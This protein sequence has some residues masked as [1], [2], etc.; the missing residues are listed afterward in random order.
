M[1]DMSSGSRR[2]RT[3]KFT[4]LC[5]TAAVSAFALG[6]G[7]QGAFAQNV[8]P[9]A[10]TTG[11]E[12]VVVVTGQRK[13]AQSAQQ[14]KRR[15]DVVVDTMVAEDAGKLPDNNV[16]DALARV[17]GV[18][19]RRDSGEANS[20]L[21]RGL[22]NIVTLLNG[23]EMFTTTGRYVAL[24]DVP[25]NMI[26]RVD[27]YKSNGASQIE[28]GIA[29]TIDVRTRRPF[30]QKGLQFNA[31]VRAQ[32]NDKAGA[33]DP[34]LG[35]TVS[36]TWDTSHGQFGALLGLS[37]T[38]SHFHEER[39]FN[40]ESVD[41]TGSFP[42][43]TLP[44]GLTSIKAPFV[45]GYIPITGDRRRTSANVAL[46]WRPNEDT[47]VYFEGFAT[48]YKND[49]ELD[50][51][52]GLP[53]LGDGNISATVYPGTNILKTLTNHNVFTI[54]STQ[55]NRQK[56]FTTQFAV[57]GTHRMGN[58]KA[59]T[60]LAVTDSTFDYENP[61]L[62]TA[63]IVPLVKVDTNHNGTAQ[64]DYGGPG[65]DIK[66]SNGF[67]LANW[68]DNYGHD[69]GKSVDWSGDLTYLPD[70]D[71]TLKEFKAGV[72]F[73]DRTAEHINQFIGG[74][75]GPNTPTN[76]VDVPGLAGLS[77]P[78][79]SGGPDYIMTQWAT[80]SA[81]FLLNH[82]GTI[83]KIFTG[84]EDAKPLDPGSFFSVKEK[85]SAVYWQVKAGGDMGAVPWSALIGVR[86]VN[87]RE[88]LKGN[89]SQ[90]TDPNHPGLEYTPID[91][92]TEA[93]NLLPSLNVKFNLTPD[94]VAR[95]AAGR[96][97]TRPNFGD[98]NPGVSLST[99]V[100]N[101]TGLTGGGGNPNLRPFTSN[102]YDLALEWY[103]AADG[104][105]TATAFDREF[106]GYIQPFYGNETFG[107]L[108]YRVTRPGNT[109]D[110]HV[111]G[112]EVGYQQFYD[113]L[114][115]IFSG[116]GLQA[117]VTYMKGQTTAF[118]TVQNAFINRPIAGLSTLS[119]NL[120]ALY[121]KGPWSARVAYNWRDKFQDTREFTPTYDLWV[122]KTAQM[123]AQVSYKLNSNVTFTLEGINLLDTNF[124]DYFVD[125][126]HPE[127]T[128]YF[129]RDTRR[130]DKTILLGFRYKM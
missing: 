128:G 104:F 81:D 36:N 20:V 86:L 25:V 8:A 74:Y 113:F 123:D 53:L 61:I 77:E 111:N 105:L 125:P 28:G 107:G 34:N 70:E 17:T 6:M 58:W 12:T 49:F 43:G 54:T 103:F 66:S 79:A 96:T 13:A 18:Q 1:T 118:S 106:K 29:G 65:F 2:G 82:T 32:Y 99:V 62:D 67:F 50:F 19:I 60:D 41:Q 78:M 9:A 71:I 38:R 46:Q 72:R 126:L 56:S 92:E 23:R 30:D 116:L 22:P 112:L 122:A 85:T 7:A 76:V 98:L 40:V 63:V 101:T 47:D 115:G 120:I 83:R 51:F 100:S 44:S 91:R 93:T 88:I 114:P 84:T 94:V 102:N 21:I 24:A 64:L 69:K 124:K 75:G 4:K 37:Y 15:S 59:S 10:S 31:N 130:Y 55:A 95:F 33:Y 110:G 14:I 80:P 16:A 42:A 57:G 90:D 45:M 117:N 109:G 27:V 129:P 119:Y 26:Q 68:F 121:E 108:N 5:L 11:D 89:L 52:V 97:L 39:A 73:A 87:T 35:A 48:E 127:L 3:A